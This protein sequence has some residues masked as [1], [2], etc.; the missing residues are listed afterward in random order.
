MNQNEIV[1][2]QYGMIP[3]PIW[4]NPASFSNTSNLSEKTFSLEPAY[5]GCKIHAAETNS[6]CWH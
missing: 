1:Q 2:P 6:Y 5:T 3:L 4:S